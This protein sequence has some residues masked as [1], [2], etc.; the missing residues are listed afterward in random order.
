MINRIL[1][2]IVLECAFLSCK[3]N[4]ELPEVKTLLV[5]QLKNT[6][7]HQEWFA[8][9]KKALEG[10]TPEQLMWKDST[11]NHSIGELVSH[12]IFWNEMNLKAFK[13]E[14]VPDYKEDN[15]ETF[16]R[17]T[18]KDWELAL[19]KLDHIQMEW[20]RSTEL[21]TATQIADWN[22]EIANMAMHTAYHTG[23][24]VYIRKR[25]GWWE[26]CR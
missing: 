10:L 1:F 13:G 19:K 14:K 7:T 17:Y 3:G 23:Q 20:E 25:N 21:A 16:I 24:I 9:T 11:E 8:P 15:K 5:Q 12:L 22:I 4:K 6:H 2:L 18:S 26:Q